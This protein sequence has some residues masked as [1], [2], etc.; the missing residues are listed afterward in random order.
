VRFFL[1]KEEEGFS[2]GCIPGNGETPPCL[3]AHFRHTLPEEGILK[4]LKNARSPSTTTAQAYPPGRL[5]PGLAL[6]RWLCSPGWQ[7]FTRI[8]VRLAGGA[9]F[10]LLS[11]F[12]ICKA[13]P[14]LLLALSGKIYQQAHYPYRTTVYYLYNYCAAGKRAAWQAGVVHPP[15]GLA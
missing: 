9:H 10:F 13:Y 1:G 5:H 6:L 7:V 12:I 15:A 11:G 3:C 2:Q 14:Q 8:K 4:R